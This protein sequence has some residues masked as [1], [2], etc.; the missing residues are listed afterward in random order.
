MGKKLT[1]KAEEPKKPC[2]A[3]PVQEPAPEPVREPET[4]PV[5]PEP[6][7]EEEEEPV[8]KPEETDPVEELQREAEELKREVEQLRSAN[9]ELK[10]ELTALKDRAARALAG[11]KVTAKSEATVNSSAMSWNDALKD[12]GG[13]YVAARRKHPDAFGRMIRENQ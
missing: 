6:E 5:K 9:E 3:E 10:E 1:A 4:E 8:V 2:A 11:L 12:C 7:A 13:D